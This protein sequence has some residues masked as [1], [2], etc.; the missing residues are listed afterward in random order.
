MEV[1]IEKIDNFGRGITY[2]DNK[3]CFVENALPEEIVDINVTREHKQ[4]KEA[5]VI[6]YKA[7]SP[8]RIKEECPF[9]NICGGCQ[10]NHMSYEEEN[11]YK[12]NKVKDIIHKF[13]NQEIPINKIKY[14][15]RN[16]YRNK[17]VL[18]G[19]N[20]K[21]GY[22]RNNTNDIIPIQ[23]CLLVNPKI[24]EIIRILNQTNKSIEEVTIKTSNDNKEALIDIKGEVEDITPLL[25]KENVV[26]LND[27]YLTEK[28]EINTMIDDKRFKVSKSSF[29]QVNNTLTKE[30][31][32]EV[33]NNIRKE[34]RNIL[35]LYCG[36]GT[37]GI[38]VAN[39]NQHVTGIDN[40]PSN[41]K[42][43]NEN[44]VINQMNHIQY[45]CNKVESQVDKL[46]EYDVIIVDPP[47]KGLDSNTKE[48]IKNNKYKK[49]IYVSCDVYTLARDL[50]DLEKYYHIISIQ[51]FN[52][53]PRTYHCESITILERR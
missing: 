38:Y 11:N 16:G 25:Q 20:K 10:L 18:H 17:V 27:K 3:I 6:S 29:F 40:N 13:M 21:L 31:Y 34:D 35:D 51:P 42:D 23:E 1:K 8:N 9:S 32:D 47:R 26:I 49:I 7:I 39:E 44:K 2:I 46:K 15:E 45:I 53:F 43:A 12:E 37:I 24:S 36:T 5:E 33:K 48:I 30:L 50:K 14:H 41:I 22:Y 19:S 52:M 28:K 4:Y